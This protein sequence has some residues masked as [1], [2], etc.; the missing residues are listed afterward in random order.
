MTRGERTEVGLA[1]HYKDDVPGVLAKWVEEI[2]PGSTL[3]IQVPDFAFVVGSYRRGRMDAFHPLVVGGTNERTYQYRTAFDEAS[4]AECMRQAGL[5]DIRH[6]DRKPGYL[7]M[8]GDKPEAAQPIIRDSRIHAVISLPRLGFNDMWLTVPEAIAPFSIPLTDARGA[9]WDQSMQT[10]IE[11][12]LAGPAQ[13]DIIWTFDYDTVCESSDIQALR[14]IMIE[15]PEVDAVIPLQSNRHT[16]TALF[17][18]DLPTGVETLDAVPASY[19][20]HPI[21]RITRGHFGCTPIRRRVFEALSKPWFK[22]HP[23]GQGSFGT[24]KLDPD[25][26][27]WDAFIRAG[28]QLRMATKVRVGHLVL[29][30][31]WPDETFAPAYQTVEDY[32]THGRP[33]IA[34]QP[35]NVD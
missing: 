4:L 30:I 16:K 27:F 2:T 31:A 14:R 15:H 11:R 35:V 32:R 18:M 3:N 19:F 6:Y 23:D 20:K 21:A 26:G 10:V 34:R 7:F 9:Y 1:Y 29:M 17:A 12:V 8:A 13:P 33:P 25:C 24:G 22:G 5:I 28:F